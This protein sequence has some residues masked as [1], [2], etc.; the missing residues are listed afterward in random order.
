MLP[1][2]YNSTLWAQFVGKIEMKV[3]GEQGGGV[4]HKVCAALPLAEGWG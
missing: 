4:K 3:A 1:A 2:L